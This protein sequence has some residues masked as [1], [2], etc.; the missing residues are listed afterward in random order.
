M[1]LCRNQ[2]PGQE[3]RFGIHLLDRLYQR[4]MGSLAK[5]DIILYLVLSGVFCIPFPFQI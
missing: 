5:G 1:L 2:L 4:D 3:D